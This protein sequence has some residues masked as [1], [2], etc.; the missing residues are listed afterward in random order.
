MLLPWCCQEIIFKVIYFENALSNP[1]HLLSCRSATVVLLLD[2]ILWYVSFPLFHAM[3][4]N[5]FN[6][7]TYGTELMNIRLL[8]VSKMNH[9]D[10]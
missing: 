3:K 4:G 2:N 5:Y 8:S 6:S 1:D 7:E 10:T 9:S